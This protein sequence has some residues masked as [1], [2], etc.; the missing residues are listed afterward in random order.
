MP[1]QLVHDPRAAHGGGG[2][3]VA[4][5]HPAAAALLFDWLITLTLT[6]TLTVF[7]N[8]TLEKTGVSITG[9]YVD[10]YGNP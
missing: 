9:V 7:Y 3:P 4:E 8:I 10:F 6:L 2:D 1:R 5:A